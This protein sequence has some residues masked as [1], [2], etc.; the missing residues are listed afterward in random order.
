MSLTTFHNRRAASI[1]TG[2]HR[3]MVLTGGGHVAE[4]LNKASGVNPLWTPPW[5]TM[6]PSDC[7]LKN[8]DYGPEAEA[9]ML[10]GVMGHNL[11]MDIYG[12]PSDEEAAAGL[13]LH[14]EASVVMYQLGGEAHRLVSRANLPLAQLAIEREV[15]LTPDSPVIRFSETVENLAGADRPIAWTEHVTLGPPFLEKGATRFCVTATRSKT[16]EGEFGDTFQIDTE[17]DWPHAPRKGGG[18]IDLRTFTDAPSSAGLTTHLMDPQRSQAY[19]IAWSQ[20]SKL[21]FGYVWN[22]SDFPWLGIWEE[23]YW[24]EAPPWGGKTL[25]RGMEFGVSPMPQTRRRMIDR[26]PLFGVPGYRWIPAQSRVRVDYCAFL[27]HADMLPGD[28][29]WDGG[30]QVKLIQ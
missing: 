1:E 12:S 20:R 29:T 24:R 27:I 19:F 10:A 3:V 11:C 23:N 7:P 13:T 18:T 6:E 30:W 9:R 28:V 25:A 5:P 15:Q 21:A 8:P 26:E 17:F 16:Y 2:T 22:R 4:I 14:G